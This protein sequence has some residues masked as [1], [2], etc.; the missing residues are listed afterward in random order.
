MVGYLRKVGGA[1]GRSCHLRRSA[2]AAD[3][4][5]PR[6]RGAVLVCASCPASSSIPDLPE[7]VRAVLR[8]LGDAGHEVA[9][10]GGA[11]RDRL[12]GLAA[13][14]RVGRRH[15][16]PSRGGRRPLSRRDL[17]EPVRDRHDRRRADRSRSPRT[18]P[19]ATYRDRRR[20][21]EVR[22]GVS[23]TEDL[24]RR[25]FTINAMAWLPI[26]LEA[27]RGTLVDPVGGQSDLDARVLRAVGDPRERFARGRPA[28]D[29]GGTVRRPPRADDRSRHRAGDPRGGADRRGR[30]GG[31][32]P[33]R[34]AAHPGAR[35]DPVG[36]DRASSSASGS[37][38]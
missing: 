3:R 26:D 1:G 20:P 35:C 25:D 23:L 10:V 37:W 16:R 6:S 28:P 21:D 32:R 5:R 29:P 24:A 31:A 11:V 9:I 18:G 17:G 12:L 4:H 22:F 13:P 30:L 2:R 7:R 14:R 36:R 34:A 19:R 27:G 38:A 33:R 15:R 8:T